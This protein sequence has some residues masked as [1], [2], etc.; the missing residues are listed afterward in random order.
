[1]AVCN[2]F[3]LLSSCRRPLL[4]V[5]CIKGYEIVRRLRKHFKNYPSHKLE[6]NIHVAPLPA[7]G[8]ATNFMNVSFYHRSA[9]LKELL[10]LLT[11]DEFS[12]VV[13]SS[14]AKHVSTSAFLLSRST[15]AQGPVAESKLRREVESLLKMV[16]E[17]CPDALRYSLKQRP[18]Y[19]LISQSHN[20][21][22]SKNYPSEKQLHTRQ[23]CKEWVKF[24]DDLNFPQNSTHSSCTFSSLCTGDPQVTLGQQER[25]R[26]IEFIISHNNGELFKHVLMPIIF[27]QNFKQFVQFAAGLVSNFNIGQNKY[28]N[29]VRNQLGKEL[30]HVLGIN[31]MVPKND[32]SEKLK[33]CKDALQESLSL[34]F[35][36]HNGVL[37]AYTNKKIVEWLLSK[38]SLK[39]T[40]LVPNEK[41][42]VYHYVDAF[43][44][45]QWSKYFNGKTAI[46]IKLVE[47]HNLLSSIATV[48]SWLGP[49]DYNHVYNL[50]QESLQQLSSLK[51]VYHPYLKMNIEVLVRGVADGCQRRSITGSSSASSTYPI[52][53]SPEHQK[54][55]EDMSIIC[56]EPV[57][58]VGMT[59]KAEEDYK[60]WLG[61]RVDNN[62]NRL[63]SFP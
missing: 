60:A 16:A 22:V 30:E 39:E 50:G 35:V 24:I 27:K 56:N 20:Y 34:D 32:M 46:R 45:M 5:D 13:L 18:A 2:F 12:T 21:S 11:A 54:Q 63:S 7:A 6:T 36:E 59:E 3:G 23:N 48:C 19:A 52:P 8:A 49:D 43:P 33:E 41:L 51:T 4:V 37:A 47:P 38:E 61:K 40:I 28:Q 62:E 42:I 9:R 1:M 57:W 14:V 29:I 44:W 15:L 55:L 10:K 26:L 31:I 58:K 17:S 53:E 25:T